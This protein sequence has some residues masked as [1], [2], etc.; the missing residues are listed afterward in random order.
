M[1]QAMEPGGSY[2]RHSEYQM[3]AG[4]SHENLVAAAASE[5][6]PDEERGSVVVADYGCAQGRVSNPLIHEAVDRIRERH[7]DVPICVYH[8]DLITNDWAGLFE[9]LRDEDSYLQA[10]DGPITP[11]ASATSFYEPVTPRHILDLGMSFASIQWL[12]APG[13][14]DCGT[15]LYFDQLEDG[16]RA[17]MA[18]QAHA[19]W[20]RFLELRAD[21]LA[22]GGRLVLDMMG[23][24]DGG[25]AAGHDL[26]RHVRTVCEDMAGEGQL[27]SDRLDNYVIPIYERSADEARR[28]FDEEIGHSLRLESLDVHA[29]P[30]PYTER[31]RQDGDAATLARGFTGFFR[32]FSGPSL[33]DAFALNDNGVEDLCRRLE[34]RIRADA[35][36]LHF[37]IHTLTLV[38]S[39]LA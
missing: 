36:D 11:L 10:A 17:R 30:N 32:A 8:N 12:A 29:Q 21:E 39:R 4:L 6:V 9:S 34:S 7:R 19:D 16:A 13:P 20:T 28:P 23:V 5:V 3:R 14:T 1:S 24:P 33:R 35:G 38:I 37:E 26:W 31:Y 18:A 27:D 2:D 22:A 15:A 25:I